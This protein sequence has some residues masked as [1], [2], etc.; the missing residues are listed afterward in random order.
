MLSSS[1]NICG[2]EGEIGKTFGRSR[3]M[4]VASRDVST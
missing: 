3:L 1:R 4:P 2:A